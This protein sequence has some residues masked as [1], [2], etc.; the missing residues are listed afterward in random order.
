MTPSDAEVRED[1]GESAVLLIAAAF[2]ATVPVA[3][4][5]TK[6]AAARR[7]GVLVRMCRQ[8]GARDTSRR[9]AVVFERCPLAH[10]PDDAG[11]V[12]RCPGVVDEE[13]MPAEHHA[14][15]TPGYGRILTVN[16][17]TSPEQ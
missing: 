9:R 6:I 12:Q 16:R 13:G 4:T 15:P 14:G 2:C 11:R 3:T 1:H 7:P 10:D 17:H 8:L 5:E